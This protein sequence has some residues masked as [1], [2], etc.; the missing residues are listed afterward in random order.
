L[1]RGWR[2]RDVAG[3]LAWVPT[4][5][6]WEMMSVAPRAGF[7][8]NRV[9]TLLALRHGSGPADQIISRI[10][11]HAGERRTAKVL[12]A[13]NSLFDAMVHSTD[14][15]IPLGRDFPVPVGF[16]RE[17]LQRVWAMGWPFS[18]RR[19]LTGLRLRATDTD[20]TVG[21]GPEVA[22]AALSLRSFS[23]GAPRPSSTPSTVP[24]SK[25]CP[26]DRIRTRAHAFGDRL[27]SPRLPDTHRDGASLVQPPCKESLSP[28]TA[29]AA[30]DS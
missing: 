12:D 7:N 20:W 3:H 27:G 10:R 16:T 18:A 23:P 25:T 1:C 24:E 13:R 14:V 5:T 30:R 17:G 26:A 9:N 19:K 2:V 28:A 21:T 29:R 4:I 22:G 8:P 11:D 6:T 15:A